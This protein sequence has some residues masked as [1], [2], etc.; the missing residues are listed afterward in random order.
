V[1]TLVVAD[2]C[3][4]ATRA[5]ARAHGAGT[6]TATGR[7]VGAARAAGAARALDELAREGRQAAEVYLLHTDCA[8]RYKR[9]D[10]LEPEDRRVHGANL[11]VRAE[12]YLRVGG[13]PALAV[14]ED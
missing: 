13:F 5:T 1:R 12:A 9:A 11:G 2:A 10:A 7:N 6:L 3:T 14:A 8:Q 4:D